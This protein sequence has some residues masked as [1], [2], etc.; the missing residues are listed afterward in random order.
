MKIIET[1][2]LF[3]IKNL[4]FN[5]SDVLLGKHNLISLGHYEK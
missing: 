4:F 2:Q 5:F 3:K 1:F